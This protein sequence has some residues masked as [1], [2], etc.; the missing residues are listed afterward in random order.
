MEQN[1]LAWDITEK[2][3]PESP[4]GRRDSS[5]EREQEAE[6]ITGQWQEPTDPDGKSQSWRGQEAHSR[7]LK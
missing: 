7:E 6:E 3:E 5:A 2:S 1:S 4:S